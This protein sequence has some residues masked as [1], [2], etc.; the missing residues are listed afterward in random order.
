MRVHKKIKGPLIMCSPQLALSSPPM[1]DT[2][3]RKKDINYI[4]EDEK[5]VS[6]LLPNCR[7]EIRIY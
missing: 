4:F 1:E 2:L 3:T 6:C 5:R 7:Y